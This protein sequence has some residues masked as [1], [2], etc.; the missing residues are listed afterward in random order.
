MGVPKTTPTELE[1]AQRAKQTAVAGSNGVTLK[2][3]SFGKHDS[4][5]FIV[6]MRNL[7]F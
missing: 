1:A 5:S 7:W 6:I 2:Q 4:V 3:T